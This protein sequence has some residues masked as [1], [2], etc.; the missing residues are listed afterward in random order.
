MEARWMHTCTLVYMLEFGLRYA[1]ACLSQGPVT[2]MEVGVRAGGLLLL[3]LL[4][5]WC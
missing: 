2:G 4:L 1:L 3:L 5:P